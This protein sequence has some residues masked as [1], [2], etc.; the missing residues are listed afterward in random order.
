MQ[1]VIDTSNQIDW[2]AT[3][4]DLK[5]QNVANVLRTFKYEVGYLRNLGLS[6][7]DL[8]VSKIKGKLT[9]EIIEQ[10]KEYEPDA[11]VI[12]V[13]VLNVDESGNPQIKVAVEFD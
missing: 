6:V 10:I 4:N 8:P 2:S 12:N 5:V 7:L 1:Y 13:D 9:T 3:G 11:T